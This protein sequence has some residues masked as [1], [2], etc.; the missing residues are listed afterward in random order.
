[1][2][3]R[4]LNDLNGKVAV[5]TG[6][7]GQIGSATAI[8]LAER[9]A[10]VVALVRRQLAETNEKLKALPLAN[11]LDHFAVE[12]SVTNTESLVAAAKEVERRAGRCD[13]LINAAGVTRNIRPPDLDTLTDKIFD[14]IV[15]TNLRG[16]FATIRTFVPLLRTSGD[17]LIINISSTAGL[18]ASSSNLAYGASK[19]GLD[20]L[21]KSLAMALAPDIR[22]VGIAPGHLVNP[23]SGATK[24]PGI[25]E[26][27]AMMT[28]LKRVGEAD[29]I[30]SAIEACATMMRYATGTIFLIDG[31]RSL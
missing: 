25:N 27:M 5:I 26:K 29:D 11:E 17:G 10:R 16:T 28:P 20:L 22:V 19:A 9:G 15:T 7:N 1:V 31:G 24:A 2:K 21:T 4:R 30:A 23:T 8:R 6:G 13:I 18:G 14:E 3:F 12:A